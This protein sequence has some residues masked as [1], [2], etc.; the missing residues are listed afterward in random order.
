[1]GLEAAMDDRA[2]HYLLF[3]HADTLSEPARWK[4]SLQIA[5]GQKVFEASDTEPEARGERLELLAVVRGLEAISRPSRVT[6]VTSSRYVRRGMAYG[7]QEWRG[8]DWSWEWYG[9]MVP[10]K[11]RDLWQRL[12]RALEFH[13][14]E[15]RRWRFDTAHSSLDRPQAEPPTAPAGIMAALPDG[16]QLPGLRR[17]T[18]VNRPR[19][20]GCKAAQTSRHRPRAGAAEPANWA[21]RTGRWLIGWAATLPGASGR[22]AA[23][24]AE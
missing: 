11:N 20:A 22:T 12:D 10:V 3:A 7:L 19:R 14:V 13:A 24:A 18:T 8:N 21:E 6:L 16:A 17:V 4:V 2:P 1:M 5:G 15:C 23:C 9:R